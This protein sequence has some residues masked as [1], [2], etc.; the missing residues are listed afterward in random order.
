MVDAAPFPALRYDP[1]V[2]GDPGSTSAPAYDDLER[3]T[4][5]SHRAASPYTILEL[6]AGDDPR[7]AGA[8]LQRWLRTGVL[9]HDPSPAYYL[10]EIHELR[11]GVPMLL[12]G[13][14]AA[15]GVDDLLPHE[16]VDPQ[17]VLARVERATHV[18]VD[19]APVFAVHT[20]APAGV[21]KVLDAPPTA[22]P[23]IAFTDEAGADH[24]VWTVPG[25][26][27]DLRRGLEEVTAVIA[28]GHHR[29]AAAR[30]RAGDDDGTTV[31]TLAYLVD[32][33]AYGPELR[34]VHRLVTPVP[35]DLLARMDALFTRHRVPADRVTHE[36]AARPRPSFGLQ[37]QGETWVLVARDRDALYRRI[38]REHS[39]AYRSLD[40]AVWHHAVHPE[41][42]GAQVS[43]R[44]DPLT[45]SGAGG[46]VE[47]AA[48]FVLRPPRFDD[49]LACAD[50]G[51]AMPEKTTW[52]RPKPRAGLV[53]RSLHSRA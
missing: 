25:A 47:G 21:R 53:M 20:Q 10:Y 24:R 37:L 12:R 5:A 46:S 31:R 7:T 29:H 42:S 32:G 41:L 13:L 22:P 26:T 33:T 39:V 49:V 2:A 19:L 34:G 36:L 43:Y 16:R 17:R 1:A 48:L 50:A 27:A 3:F 4:Y 15:V 18:P 38:P 30:R 40:A 9:T 8:V 51:D 52:F 14:L 44:S 23:I 45:F 6:L 35:H 28:D 11:H